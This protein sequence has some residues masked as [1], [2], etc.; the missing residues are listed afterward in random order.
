MFINLIIKLVFKFLF[1]Q[2]YQLT[3]AVSREI[4]HCVVQYDDGHNRYYYTVIYDVWRKNDFNFD[5]VDVDD[6]RPKGTR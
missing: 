4:T 6:S 3:N 1:Y 2:L 5:L